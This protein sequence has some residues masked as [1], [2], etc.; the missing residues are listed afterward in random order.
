MTNLITSTVKNVSGAFLEEL[1]VSTLL[2]S[3]IDF[4]LI[5]L[6]RAIRLFA[7]GGV[8]IVIAL[9]LNLIGFNEGFIG[10][11][12]T[13]TMMGD[14]FVS[15]LLAM[16][17]DKWGRK[18][19]MI[20]SNIIMCITAFVFYFFQSPKVLVPMTIIGF[21]TPSGN[22]VGPF[23]SIEQ[24]VIACL[25]P[26]EQ[27]SDCYAWYSFLGILSTAFGSFTSGLFIAFAKDKLNFSDISSYKLPFLFLAIAS[28]MMAILSCIRFNIE[29]D[30]FDD[31]QVQEHE[32][33]EQEEQTKSFLKH[34][35]QRQQDNSNSFENLENQSLSTKISFK[36]K[37]FKNILDPKSLDFV[38]KIS[39]LFVLDTAAK[40][41]I[42]KAWIS[43]YIKHKFNLEP[44]YLGFVFFIHDVLSASAA[45]VGSSIS[46]RQGVIFTM[47]ATHIPTIFFNS[48]IPFPKSLGL[49]VFLIWGRATFQAMDLSSKAVFITSS[50]KPSERT[51]VIA[52]TNVCRSIGQS[53][54]PTVTG[55]FTNIGMQWITFLISGLLRAFYDF[56]IFINFWKIRHQL[57]KDN[58]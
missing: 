13:L 51:G 57:N 3:P 5:V 45:L 30:T 24:S 37:N 38:I 49:T 4:K 58:S 7:F 17:A 56:G 40:S 14:L 28:I 31:E 46:K 2:E 25:V 54:A 16:V 44:S 23:R 35:H 22:E 8:S 36:F 9:Y 10:F 18:R 32:P 41:L 19:V 1:G 26:F 15:F 50:V 6:I 27:R 48:L 55:F 53:A 12:F 29:L 34:P 11:F 52:W 33:E 20:C 42:T 39:L 47:L 21:I 43:Y